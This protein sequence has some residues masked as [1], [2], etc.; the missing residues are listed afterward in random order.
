MKMFKVVA[1]TVLGLSSAIATAASTHAKVEVTSK[2]NPDQTLTIDFKV[3]ADKGHA[4]TPEAPWK[5]T[6]TGAKDLVTP[7]AKGEYSVKGLNQSLPGLSL[8]SNKLAAGK[9]EG[10]LSYTVKAFI[11]TLDKSNC[12]PETYK[13]EYQWQ[14]KGK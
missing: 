11:C 8:T 3:I 5:L 1:S 14:Y 13:G 12:Y 2:Q 7:D 6:V 9:A 10:K 4:L